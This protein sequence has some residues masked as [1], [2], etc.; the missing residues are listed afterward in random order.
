MRGLVQL[1]LLAGLI[2]PL[3]GCKSP[4]LSSL[5]PSLF[6]PE[7]GVNDEPRYVNVGSAPPPPVNHWDNPDSGKEMQPMQV[8]ANGTVTNSATTHTGHAPMNTAM[9]AQTAPEEV[10][11]KPAASAEERLRR[12][13]SAVISLRHDVNALIPILPKYM[14]LENDIRILKG[15]LDYSTSAYNKSHMGAGTNT[16]PYAHP[17]HL[18]ATAQHTTTP[19]ATPQKT[20]KKPASA[21]PKK[22]T[23]PKMENPNIIGVHHIRL[24]EHADKTRVVF[25]INGPAEYRYDFDDAENILLI[26][27]P[28]SKW[29]TH[30]SGKAKKA[31]MIKSFSVQ[32]M[33]AQGSMVVVLLQEGVRIKQDMLL[34]PSKNSPYNR[35]VFDLVK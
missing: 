35:L 29:Q 26:E 8:T 7:V 28:Q 21:A 13:E 11:A 30:K 27:L 32:D 3:A 12:I 18:S 1:C 23:P 9:A 25:D 31:D 4:T 14:S 19:A 20:H 17:G 5:I 2:F 15:G 34:K 6:G 10:F 16:S 22:H 33:G 24:G